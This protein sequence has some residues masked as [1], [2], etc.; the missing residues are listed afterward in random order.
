VCVCVCVCV[1]DP[2]QFFLWPQYK[3]LQFSIKYYS[4][5]TVDDKQNEHVTHIPDVT[6]T[7]LQLEIT[8]KHNMNMMNH[9]ILSATTNRA[10]TCWYHCVLE[11]AN[12]FPC[13]SSV[14]TNVPA[15]LPQLL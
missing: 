14:P 10:A 12:E 9:N 8:S 3:H 2:W 13:E 1:C 15:A 11:D 5:V 6:I 7:C 4:E